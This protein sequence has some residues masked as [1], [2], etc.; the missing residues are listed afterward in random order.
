MTTIPNIDR[1][2]RDTKL[3]L[4][5]TDAAMDEV[6]K[7]HIRR[8]IDTVKYYRP[9]PT[10]DPDAYE[11]EYHGL[12]VEMTVYSWNKRGH[13]GAVSAGENGVSRSYEKGSYPLSMT[14]RIT[15]ILTGC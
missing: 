1:A 12:I 14:Q 8:A 4:G 5:I 2:L 7:I 3:D 10:F 13:D 15:P 9:Q 11:G 6:I